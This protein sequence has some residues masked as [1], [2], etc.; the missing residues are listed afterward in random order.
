M[1]KVLV[2]T[3]SKYSVFITILMLN[4]TNSIDI[5]SAVSGNPEHVLATFPS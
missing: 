1:K 4:L 5:G 2:G 3:F